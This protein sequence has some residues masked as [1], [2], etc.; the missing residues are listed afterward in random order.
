MRVAWRCLPDSLLSPG[1]TD[2]DD[3]G[4]L[5]IYANM[6]GWV[7]GDAFSSAL[8]IN[9][10]NQHSWIIVT[11]RAVIGHLVSAT[12]IGARV[13]L[14]AVDAEGHVQAIHRVVSSG[15]SYGGNSLR[16]EVGLGLAVA[17]RRLRV[18]WPSGRI[19]DYDT[20]PIRASLQIV[21]GGTSWSL[22]P[23][24]GF[25]VQSERGSGSCGCADN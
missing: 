5:D 18:R 6:G 17:V 2:L 20:P 25:R 10:G 13:E 22:L 23:L 19:Q 4:T 12:A 16:L 21:E 11:L 9:P 3:D 7:P 15:G 8:F 1:H 24:R 14:T